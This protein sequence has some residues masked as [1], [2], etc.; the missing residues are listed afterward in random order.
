MPIQQLPV[1]QR[2]AGGGYNGSGSGSISSVA[3]PI[4]T[5]ARSGSAGSSE[6]VSVN[7]GRSSASP[8][9]LD[10]AISIGSR[11][12]TGGGGGGNAFRAPS[13][14]QFLTSASQRSGG[15][16]SGTG[17]GVGVRAETGSV[18]G[19]IASSNSG[20][21]RVADIQRDANRAPPTQRPGGGGGEG[22]GRGGGGYN[23][24]DNNH[25]VVSAYSGAEESLG[26]GLGTAGGSVYDFDGARQPV[27]YDDGG[28]HFGHSLGGRRESETDDYGPSSAFY[29][30]GVNEEKGPRQQVQALSNHIS[31]S[32]PRSRSNSGSGSVRGGSRSGSR[33]DYIDSDGHFMGDDDTQSTAT[34][35]YSTNSSRYRQQQQQQQPDYE[36]NEYDELSETTS[37]RQRRSAAVG[38][39]VSP[40]ES[41]PRFAQ[42]S[43]PVPSREP[44]P[45]RP[46]ASARQPSPQLGTAGRRATSSASP[47]APR[48]AA[49]TMGG[50]PLWAAAVDPKTS[51]TYWYNRLVSCREIGGCWG[52]PL[53]P[54]STALLADGVS[55]SKRWK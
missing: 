53:L 1:G 14:S 18:G 51:R 40:Y 47:T 37:S 3:R 29:G 22:G 50:G 10:G 20:R 31:L 23:W 39:R 46:L 36:H 9:S 15:P 28:S 27:I 44:S 17:V 8:R 19:S 12:F 25:S 2:T 52:K 4:R 24:E 30:H 42:Q 21:R 48:M 7:S 38:G 35:S 6:A 5:V 43:M 26:G 54:V 34:G 33:N 49:G 16:V 13:P 41:S 32:L 11:S 55:F 45:G